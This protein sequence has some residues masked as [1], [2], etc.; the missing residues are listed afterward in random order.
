MNRSTSVLRR[1]FMAAAVLSG[2]AA[3]YP[4]LAAPDTTS[5]KGSTAL[6]AYF[7]RSGNTRVI[8][9]QIHRAQK[10]VLFEIQPAQPYPDDYLETVEQARRERDRGYRP[11]LKATVAD[12]ARYQTIYLGFP[13]WGGTVPPVIRAFLAAHDFKGK[14]IIP[15]ITHGGYGI[16][17]SLTILAADV[18]GGR[19]LDR[20]LVMQAD[21]ERQTLEQVTRWLS[22]FT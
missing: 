4:A 22:A 9:G 16:G 19:L 6:V 13:I 12:F 7:S 10:A 1:K 8:A 3:R 21:Q 2:L 20:G 15:F 14:T 5:R 18:P 17:N 11:P